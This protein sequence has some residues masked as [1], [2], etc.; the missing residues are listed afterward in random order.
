MVEKLRT[1]NNKVGLEINL[2]KTKVMFNRNVEIQ[3][4]MTENVALDQ[5][6]RYAYLGQRISIH[7]DW[8]PEVRR[9]VA[10][11]NTTNGHIEGINLE[12]TI[13][14]N[15]EAFLG[16]PYA[17]PPLGELRFEKPVPASKWTDVYQAKKLPKHCSQFNHGDENCLYLNVYR[18]E[19]TSENASEKKPV[20]IWIHGGG[21]VSGYGIKHHESQAIKGNMGLYD[22]LLVFQWVHEN[23]GRF[24]GDP[25]R[26]VLIGYSAGAASVHY[27]LLISNLVSTIRPTAKSWKLSADIPIEPVTFTFVPT[28]D[29]EIVTTAPQ[30]TQLKTDTIPVMAVTN[31]DEGSIFIN[32]SFP[33]EVLEGQDGFESR[34]LDAVLRSMMTEF[35][36]SVQSEIIKGYTFRENIKDQNILMTVMSNF[37]SDKYFICPLLE[38]LKRRSE[39]NQVFYYHFVHQHETSRSYKP[40]L[41]VRHNSFIRFLLGSPLVNKETFSEKEIET[42]NRILDKFIGF[43]HNGKVDD[44]PFPEGYTEISLTDIKKYGHPHEKR[45]QFLKSFQFH[46]NYSSPVSMQSISSVKIYD[47]LIYVKEHLAKLIPGNKNVDAWHTAF[48]DVLPKY[49]INTERRMAHFISQCAHES[50]N[51]SS[52]EENLN[53][54]EKALNAVFGRYFGAAPKRNAAEYARTPEMIA[55]YVYMDEFRKYKMGNTHE[56]DGWLFR[57]RGLMQLTGRM[58]YARFAKTVDMTAEEAVVYVATE[59][60]AVQSAC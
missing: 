47:L 5:I 38:A 39:Y 18:P 14:N 23:I 42:V 35:S 36:G 15:L 43:I 28:I 55:N 19:G 13:G 25:K 46:P 9:R 8:E 22:Q 20:V 34:R 59:A 40:W 45:C 31:E 58:N 30:Q 2:S 4:I 6:D 51:F 17:V 50:N 48:R 44:V 3:P 16:I 52:L 24:G 1:A 41:G 33:L 26:V 37:I 60:G 27:H 29:G 10:L 56:G 12:N 49:S 54:S 32:L 53:Y 7:R 21:F 57:G 11:V